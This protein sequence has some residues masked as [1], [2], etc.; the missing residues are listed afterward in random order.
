MGYIFDILS[1][2]NNNIKFYV[3]FLK[4]HSL[5]VHFKSW[6]RPCLAEFP[7]LWR[8]QKLELTISQT[9]ALSTSLPEF[10]TEKM[11]KKSNKDYVYIYK[12][13]NLDS[14]KENIYPTVVVPVA[15]ILFRK[16]ALSSGL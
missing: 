7:S 11:I 13:E 1:P 2:Y 5:I 16:T 15:A 14:F 3:F 6:I 4:E 9:R 8:H 12:V 10:K